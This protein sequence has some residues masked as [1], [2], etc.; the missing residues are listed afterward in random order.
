MVLRSQM[1][2][3]A[4]LVPEHSDPPPEDLGLMEAIA[5]VLPSEQLPRGLALVRGLRAQDLTVLCLI[6]VF[7]ITNVNSL[8]V[9]GGSAFLYLGLGFVAFLIPSAVVCLQLYRLFPA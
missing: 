5:P 4:T 9:G 3:Q 8:A 6:A 7:L 2:S 1:M